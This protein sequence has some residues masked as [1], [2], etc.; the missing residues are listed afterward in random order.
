MA[1][2]EVLRQLRVLGQG[3]V[4]GRGGDPVALDDHR[5][6]VG[7][8]LGNEKADQQ[9]ERHDGVEVDAVVDVV[10]EAL[11][12]LDDDQGADLAVGE[13]GGRQRDLVEGR[14]HLAL[15]APTEQRR[16]AE[17]GQS[18]PNLV[19]E[20][21]DDGDRKH[22]QKRLERGGERSELE[23]TRHVVGDHQDQD[24]DQDLD[25]AGTADQEQQ[26]VDDERHQHHVDHVEPARER[27]SQ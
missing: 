9:V 25:L 19:L 11:Q 13:R 17:H 5:A 14:G 1:G 24:A 6:V 26:V 10:S 15:I 22:R 18:A 3:Q 7:R 27:L 2:A 12:P 8:G 4:A 16:R 21:H 20:E 23:E